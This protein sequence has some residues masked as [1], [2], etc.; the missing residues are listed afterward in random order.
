MSKSIGNT[1]DPLSVID[2]G[3]N[4]KTQPAYGAD[5]LRLWVA[6]IDYSNDVSIGPNIIKQVWRPPRP[7]CVPCTG[8]PAL[9]HPS[10][11]S[12]RRCVTPALL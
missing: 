7:H 2:G 5:V 1:V 11:V 4:L 8:C 12:P 10:A 9:C 6:S 3:K